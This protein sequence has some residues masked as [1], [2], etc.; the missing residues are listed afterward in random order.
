MRRTNFRTS[1]TWILLLLALVPIT[2]VGAYSAVRL[3]Q[4]QREAVG[5]RNGLIA[6]TAAGDVESFLE[7][8]VV[9]LSQFK[10]VDPDSATAREM[11]RSSASSIPFIE[12]IL[13][14][15]ADGKVRAAAVSP[16]HK[17]RSG[18]SSDSNDRAILS[19]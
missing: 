5:F 10:L 13:L 14:V 6:Q 8:P 11:L 9:A 12:S 17:M 3:A 4:I 2:V 7:A 19:S 1:L 15:D 18:I 16:D